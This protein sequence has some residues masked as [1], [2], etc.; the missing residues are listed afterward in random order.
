MSSGYFTSFIPSF[1]F[2]PPIITGP[3]GLVN[4]DDR[5]C[6]AP[7]FTTIRAPT[8]FAPPIQPS[9][10]GGG[11]FTSIQDSRGCWVI[12]R[13]SPSGK[14]TDINGDRFDRAHDN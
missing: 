11:S 14:H 4:L 7:L 6:G 10:T 5:K 8:S 3:N 1:V 13:F 9:R 2:G 12:G